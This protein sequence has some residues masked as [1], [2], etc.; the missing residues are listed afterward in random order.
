MAVTRLFPAPA[1]FRLVIDI[2]FC[3]WC[4]AIEP[5]LHPGIRPH[6]NRV[7]L[8]SRNRCRTTA[9]QSRIRT[10]AQARRQISGENEGADFHHCRPVERA[11]TDRHGVPGGIGG[12]D[13][14]LGPD[15]FEPSRAGHDPS[16]TNSGRSHVIIS[17]LGMNRVQTMNES[18]HLPGGIETNTRAES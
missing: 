9:E 16:H 17:C 10:I 5:Q 4:A 15:T 2:F 13:Q 12:A 8:C 3:R 18:C 11:M 1:I 14:I 7:G 6:F